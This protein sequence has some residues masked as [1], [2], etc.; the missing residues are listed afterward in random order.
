VDR[1]VFGR[2]VETPRAEAA[3]LERRRREEPDVRRER[4]RA[5]RRDGCGKG[6]RQ[7]FDRKGADEIG[8]RRKI[9]GRWRLRRL[10]RGRNGEAAAKRG[11]RRGEPTSS[12]NCAHPSLHLQR[13]LSF[14]SFLSYS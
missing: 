11:D 10:R 2:R 9:L 1:G 4:R 13:I 8:G 12:A 3:S 6:R 5:K 7:R 14:F